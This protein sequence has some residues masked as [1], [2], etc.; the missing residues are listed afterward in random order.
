MCTHVS[1][2]IG[3]R[4]CIH[5]YHPPDTG[6]PTYWIQETPMESCLLC[7][8]IFILGPDKAIGELGQAL[9]K[10]KLG[11]HGRE[12]ER[13]EDVFPTSRNKCYPFGVQIYFFHSV[14]IAWLCFIFLGPF[15]LNEKNQ[16]CAQMSV[17]VTHALMEDSAGWET[18][19]S[20]A[21]GSDCVG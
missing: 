13:A 1:P 21:L 12:E 2:P 17:T 7:L 5:V 10:R 18:V 3:C 6:R 16:I 14:H 11:I 8:S 4:M 15:A 9:G 19:Y 20:T